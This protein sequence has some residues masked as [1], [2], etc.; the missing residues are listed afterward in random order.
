MFF[1]LMY[2]GLLRAEAP[3]VTGV[4]WTGRECGRSEES[5]RRAAGEEERFFFVFASRFLECR[6]RKNASLQNDTIG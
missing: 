5:H 2:D 4:L 1:A 3:G 6:G